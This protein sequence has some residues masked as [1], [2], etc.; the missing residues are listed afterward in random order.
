V[1]AGTRYWI[2]RKGDVVV[3]RRDGVTEAHVGQN[4]PGDV[5]GRL[6]Y[7]VTNSNSVGIEFEG[8]GFL[9]NEQRQAGSALNLFLQA[10]HDIPPANIFAHQKAKKGGINEGVE[11]TNIVRS[12]WS[13]PGRASEFL[14]GGFQSLGQTVRE[15]GAKT[16]GWI[17]D[18]TRRVTGAVQE[19]V[20]YVMKTDTSRTAAAQPKMPTLSQ[21]ARQWFAENTG[22]KTAEP[23][24]MAAARYGLPEGP[25][26]YG[27]GMST[28]AGVP[29]N[30]KVVFGPYIDTMPAFAQAA[31]SQGI[32]PAGYVNTV[33]QGSSCA[34]YVQA[35]KARLEVI[36][37]HREFRFTDQATMLEYVGKQIDGLKQLGIRSA[38]FDNVDGYAQSW[39]TSVVDLAQ[40]KDFGV[41]LKNP[42]LMKGDVASIVRKPNVVGFFVEQ[43]PT[44]TLNN[45]LKLRADAGRPD[46]TVLFAGGHG[47]TG[48]W[49]RNIQAEVATGKYQNVAVS[50]GPSGE[51]QGVVATAWAPPAGTAQVASGRAASLPVLPEKFHQEIK[52]SYPQAKGVHAQI[53]FDDG[54][55][56]FPITQE[57]LRTLAPEVAKAQVTVDVLFNNGVKSVPLAQA[58]KALESAFEVAAKATTLDARSVLA[59][60]LIGKD[61]APRGAPV[62]KASQ[63]P[64]FKT[65]TSMPIAFADGTQGSAALRTFATSDYARAHAAVTAAVKEGKVPGTIKQVQGEPLLWSDPQTPRYQYRADVEGTRVTIMKVDVQGQKSLTPGSKIFQPQQVFETNIE[66]PRMGIV[67]VTKRTTDGVPT[68]NDGTSVSAKSIGGDDPAVKP[69]DT[70]VAPA[71]PAVPTTPLGPISIIN[72]PGEAARVSTEPPLSGWKKVAAV[73]TGVIAAPLA[74]LG[75]GTDGAPTTPPVTTTPVTPEGKESVVEEKSVDVPEGKEGDGCVTKVG[76]DL[77]VTVECPTPAPSETPPPQTPST[78]IAGR[79]GDGRGGLGRQGGQGQPQTPQGGGGSPQGGAPTTQGKPPV[80]GGVGGG[81]PGIPAVG[82]NNGTTNKTL[83]QLTCPVAT[84]ADVPFSVKWVCAPGMTSQG[85]G[86]STGGLVGGT[87]TTSITATTTFGLA[88]AGTNAAAATCTTRVIAPKTALTAAPTEVEPGQKVVIAWVTTDTTNCSLYGPQSILRSG[89]TT[90]IHVIPS[91]SRSTEFAL[92]CGTTGGTTIKRTVV[93][94]VRGSAGEIDPAIVPESDIRTTPTTEDP[95]LE[96]GTAPANDQNNTGSPSVNGQTNTSP[97]GYTATDQNGNQITLC[98]PMMGIYRFTQCLL[99]KPY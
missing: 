66:K 53:W 1:D 83:A 96:G 70:S 81:A 74:Y 48:P 90:N 23:V 27:I 26:G 58:P 17:S 49:I 11:I 39:V 22:A 41:W 93:V 18:T 59:Q 71:A 77:G 99:K 47:N 84:M 52:L 4:P 97:A 50:V 64:L 35:G 30:V 88:C 55:N 43:D 54:V 32:T 92:A 34:G 7:N 29:S 37:G 87:A 56:R 98:D 40:Q 33:C 62:T 16:A 19:Q 61:I 69:G 85:T 68:V 20:R 95:M 67:T 3:A 38:D 63:N 89:G 24:R 78:R 25:I 31:R 79:E 14:A 21:E 44:S 6:L 72:A 13:V 86:F 42:N 46:V 45:L 57:Q 65:E 94:R 51:Y 8:F 75:I 10:R 80:S 12:L 73:V 2:T 91:L 15:A 5:Q 28:P 9:T 36:G 82:A 60:N 76:A